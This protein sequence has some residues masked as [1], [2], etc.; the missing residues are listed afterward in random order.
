LIKFDLLVERFDCRD[1]SFILV[2]LKLE[3]SSRKLQ[4]FSNNKFW[5]TTCSYTDIDNPNK[6]E[7][8]DTLLIVILLVLLFGGGGW[9]YSRWRR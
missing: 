2:S 4:P 8:M 9:G 3:R 6:G 1:G 5:H 7:T